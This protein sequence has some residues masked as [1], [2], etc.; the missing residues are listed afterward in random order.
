MGF[1]KERRKALAAGRTALSDLEDA[2]NMLS[3]ARDWGIYDTFFNGGFVSGLM[4]HSR[5]RDAEAC[6]DRARDGLIGFSNE[7]RDLNLIGINLQPGDLKGLNFNN[8]WHL[9]FQY[10]KLR[11]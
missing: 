4:K 8:S 2:R 10:D 9:T 11:T 5:M 6:I 3:R 1:E 7:L